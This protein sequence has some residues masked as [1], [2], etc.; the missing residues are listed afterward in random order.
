MFPI[1]DFVADFKTSGLI[2]RIQS[3]YDVIMIWLSGS[4]AI[5]L[6]DETSDYD[7]GVLVADPIVFSKTEKDSET[8]V[9]ADGEI[10]VS[11]QCIYNALEDVAA[12]FCTEVLAPYRYLG[13]AQFK[14]LSEDFIIYNDK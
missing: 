7:I 10:R 1:K 14:Y 2:E 4:T 11:V 13:W 9:Y 3:R 8:Y 5:G 6:A 12:E